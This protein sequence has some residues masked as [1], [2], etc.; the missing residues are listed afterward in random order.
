MYYVGI[1]WADRKYDLL[2]LND[3]GKKVCQPFVIRKSEQGFNDLLVKLRKLSPHPLDFKIGIETPHNLLVDSLLVWNYP[4]FSIHPSSMKSFRKRYRTTN[5]RDDVYDSFV[6]ADVARTDTA[7]WRKIDRGSDLSY[8]IRLLVFDHHRLIQKQ[9]ALHNAFKETLKQYYPEYLSFFKDISCPVS[10]AFFKTFP[11][12]KLAA[13]LTYPQLKDCFNEHR[14]HGEKIIQNIYDVLHQKSIPVTESIVEIKSLKALFYAQQLQ[15]VNMSCQLY[16]Q[17]IQNNIT[18]HPDYPIF[19]SFPGIGEISSAR[20]IALFGDNRNLYKN[21]STIQS[22]AG[23]CPVTEKTGYDSYN[24]KG[25]KFI[26]FR[27]ASNKVFRSFVYNIAFSSLTKAGWV[28]AYYDKQ[29]AKGH[30]HPHAIRCLANLELK[31]LFSMWKNKTLYDENIYLAQKSR[32]QIKN[33]I[34]F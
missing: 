7:C 24:K 34:Y 15:Q 17:K 25:H 10:L 27:K 6:L 12:F 16:R 22:I 8:Q 21:V 28:K 3:Q 23:T 9:T 26:Y 20:M 33:K 19:L 30:T 31:I 14:L 1:D 32:Q 29:R 5:A 2:I 13:E 18:N 11:N 4:V